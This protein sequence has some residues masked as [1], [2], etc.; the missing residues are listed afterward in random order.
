MA[1]APTWKPLQVPGYGQIMRA[2]CD[3]LMEEILKDEDRRK[4]VLSNPRAIHRELFQG[5]TPDGYEHY[6]GSYRGSESNGL[7]GREVAGPSLVD[8]HNRFQFLPAGQVAQKM[9]ELLEF[10]DFAVLNTPSEPEAKLGNLAKAFGYFGAIHPF[11]DGNGHVQRALFAAMATAFKIPLSQRFS[12]HPRPYD[13]LLMTMLELFT[14]SNGHQD[15]IDRVGEYLRF[16][17]D[18]PFA[19]PFEDFHE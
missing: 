13:L 4:V 18:G 11:L 15:D 19:K 10:I 16:F 14:R 5:L 6:A 3:R 2:R 7:K 12:I 17:L 1:I 9:T 8:K